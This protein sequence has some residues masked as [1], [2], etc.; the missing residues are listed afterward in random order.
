M[1]QTSEAIAMFRK[2][3]VVSGNLVSVD[4][5]KLMSSID[6]ARMYS[7]LGRCYLSVN[8]RRQ[9]SECFVRAQVL[10]ASAS[11]IHSRN[12][13]VRDEANEVSDSLSGANL[14]EGLRVSG[15]AVWA[16]GVPRHRK[17]TCFARSVSKI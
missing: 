4:P 6:L 14:H 15:A 1:G 7:H 9:A 5:K 10:F 17:L 3:I 11:A 16:R 2:C 8:N 12:T 13:V